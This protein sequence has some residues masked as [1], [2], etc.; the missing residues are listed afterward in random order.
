MVTIKRD[1]GAQATVPLSILSEADQKYIRAWNLFKDFMD[2]GCFK[3]S[4]KRKRMDDD[5]NS[6]RGYNS[7]RDVDNAGY[8]LRLE[9]KSDMK[10]DKLAVEYS[11]FYEQEVN[12]QTE[13]GVFCGK[14]DVD[15]LLP[16]SKKEVQTKTVKIYREELDSDWYYGSGAD[17]VQRGVVH[18]IWLRAST[19]LPDGEKVVR[20]YSLPDSLPNS[21][22]W[23][24]KSI[25]VGMNK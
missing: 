21:R 8:E 10:F 14:L 20:E 1:N 4:A 22:A 2:E 5:A 6:R 15:K 24:T 13:Q 16:K 17:N 18:G 25:A 3:I 7:K 23:T 11:I 12:G 19:T 9:N